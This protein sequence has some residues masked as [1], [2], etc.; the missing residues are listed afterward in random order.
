MHPNLV[1]VF[2][3]ILCFGKV[4]LYSKYSNKC[5]TYFRSDQINVHLIPHSHDDA[6][7]KETFQSYYDQGFIKVKDIYDTVIAELGKNCERT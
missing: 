5:D 7:W 1:C 3:I 2:T 4:I 6:G